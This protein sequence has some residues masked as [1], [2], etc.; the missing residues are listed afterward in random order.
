MIKKIF[1]YILLSELVSNIFTQASLTF[2]DLKIKK[3]SFSN[4]VITIDDS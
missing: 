3:M 1:I 2:T 4:T